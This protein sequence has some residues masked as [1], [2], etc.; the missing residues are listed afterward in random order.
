M[1]IRLPIVLLAVSSVLSFVMAFLGVRMLAE[2][3]TVSTSIYIAL[4]M[5]TFQGG[6]VAGEIPW[7]LEVGRFLAPATT[8]GGVYAAAH[9]FFRRVWGQFRLRSVRGH[10][11]VC[12]AGMK[13]MSLARELAASGVFVVLVDPAEPPGIDALR[14]QGV[15]VIRGE[16]GDPEIH[17]LAGLW[18]AARM[19]C[20]SGDDRINIGMALAAASKLPKDRVA[21]P[22]EIHVHVG[23]VTTRNILQRNRLFDLE[24]DL[25]HRIRLFNC[26][27]NRARLALKAIP[28]EW[29]AAG[30]L[31][32]DVHLIVGQLSGL[33]RALVVHSAH[34]GHFRNGT[35]VQV[36]L[37]SQNAEADEA[38]LLKEYPGFRNCAGLHAVAVEDARGF[39]EAVALLVGQFGPEALVTVV[40]GGPAEASVTD[41]LL[42]GE[43]LKG[44]P[45]LRVLLDS[46]E[47]SGIREMVSENPHVSSWIRFLP[48]I[49]LACGKGVVF[50]HELDSVARR[51]HGVWKSGTDRRIK[52]AEASGDLAEAA[53]HRAKDTYRDWD[54]LTEEQKDANR[55]AADHLETKVRAIGCDPSAR[56]AVKAVWAALDVEQLEMLARI[57]HERWAA[58]LW[59]AGW[60][61][62]PR[63]DARRIHPNL[64]AYDELDQGTK[65]Y[66]IEQVKALPTYL[67][68]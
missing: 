61:P 66:D 4:Q 1:K 49:G 34:T 64:V 29:E 47:E 13:G 65:D 7:T 44:G 41:A 2:G 28:L 27:T 18:R 55:L 6:E 53:K 8:L 31:H 40:P 21:N 16:G 45:C 54:R 63:D 38:A 59:M 22:L 58:P 56:E 25:R 17:R 26:F 11:V 32:D 20:V 52:E 5:F 33:E 23:D 51:I 30:G 9:A 46:S 19:V 39:V 67:F 3:Y 60:L 37:V 43:R 36:H 12:G 57:E 68:G 14:G 48:E 10:T 24:H 50:N 42:L 35:K 15:V 62:G